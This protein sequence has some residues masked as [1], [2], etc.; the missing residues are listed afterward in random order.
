MRY[1][2]TGGSG[3]IGTHLTKQLLEFDP[4]CQ[5]VNVDINEA[6]V[7]DHRLKEI[8]VNINQRDELLKVDISEV[9][10]CIHLAALCKEPGFEWEEYFETNHLGTVNVISLCEKLNIKKI[11]FTS[12]MMVYQ[13]GE[14]ERTE[15]SITA[16]DT[17][18]GISKLLA[19]RELLTWKSGSYDRELKIIRPAVVFGENENG[20]FTR[21][22]KSLKRGFFPY[23]GKSDTIKSNIYVIELVHFIEFLLHFEVDNEVFNMAFP[24]RQEIRIIVKSI[25]EVLGLKAINPIIPYGLMLAVSHV[26]EFLNAIG[27]KNPIHHRRIQKLYSSTHIFPKNV[28]ESG[29]K[30]KFT[31]YTALNDWKLNDP[32]LLGG[33]KSS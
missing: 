12:T 27:L 26:F 24:E 4:L 17:A 7:V 23:V 16:P 21:L 13:A 28:L 18:Y 30:F 32:I 9:D 1:L 25:K 20:N 33:S 3:F 29:Y 10:V 14:I 19:E 8:K 5:I 11:I 22:Y 6:K 2:I 15:K 31:F